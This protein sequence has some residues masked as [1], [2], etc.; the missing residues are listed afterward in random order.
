MNISSVKYCTGCFACKSICPKD[1]IS[2]K[3]DEIGHHYPVID[4]SNCIDCGACAKICPELYPLQK[5]KA[6]QT[7]AAYAIDNEILE[8]TS[9]GGL[10]TVFSEYVVKNGGIVYGCSFVK[11]FDFQHIRCDRIEDLVKLKGSKY[12]QSNTSEIWKQFKDDIKNGKSVLFI[13][14]PCQ[15]A[16]ARSISRNSDNLITIDLVCHGVPS[17]DLLKASLPDNMVGQNISDIRFRKSVNFHFS[18]LQDKFCLYD[19]P[20]YRNW[21]MK[22]FFAKLFYRNSCYYCQ[23]ARPARVSD[24]TLGDFWGLDRTKFDYDLTKGVSMV[25]VNTMKGKSLLNQIKEQIKYAG[26][27]SETAIEGNSQLQHPVKKTW[28]TKLFRKLYPWLGLNKSVK[29]CLP[30]VAIKSFFTGITKNNQLR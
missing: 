24:I 8:S 17:L 18:I 27:P 19:C 6:I 10:A 26:Q 5:N 11:P 16:A 4:A 2:I 3:A 28:K 1:C 29:I 23:Y 21:Y 9:S 22:G 20:L 7:Y 13:G 25:M 15:A 30:A 12:V 14:T